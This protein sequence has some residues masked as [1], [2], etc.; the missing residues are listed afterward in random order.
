MITGQSALANMHTSDL[1]EPAK[2]QKLLQNMSTPNAVR[3]GP[4]P[5]DP[6]TG[7]PIPTQKT[8]PSAPPTSTTSPFLVDRRYTIQPAP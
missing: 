3:F 4:Y 2:Q 5:W 6:Q 1:S 8:P 7:E